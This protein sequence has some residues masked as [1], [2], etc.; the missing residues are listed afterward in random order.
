[1]ADTKISA[2][3]DGST[4]AATDRL[5]V[6]RS[7]FGSS[8]NRYVTPAYIKDYILALANT[9]ASGQIFVAPQLGTPASGTMTN[10]TGLPISTGVSGLGSNV[11]TFLAT[12]SSA[13]LASAVTDE[14]GSGALVFGTSPTITTKVT[15]TGGTVTTSTP[16]I[17]ATQTWNDS[18]VTFTGI[19]SNVTDTNSA[20]ASLLMDLQVGGSSKFAVAKSGNTTLASAATLGWSTDCLL[21]RDAADVL[22][23]RN[24]TTAQTFRIYNTYTDSSNYERGFVGWN[25]NVLEIGAAGAGTGSNSR[26]VAFIQNGGYAFTINNLVRWYQPFD[27]STDNAYD[28]GSSGANR[29]RTIYAG[30]SVVAAGVN[31]NVETLIIS[32]S[33]ETTAITTGTA[34]TTFRM[35]WGMTLTAVRASLTTA[36][37]SGTPTI[38]INDGGVSILS[39]KI[40]IDANE[41]TSTTAATPAVISDTALADDAEITIDIDVAGTNAA[42]LKVYL[43]GTRL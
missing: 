43:I 13:N 26:P 7:P 29:P 8:D 16:V 9:W 17:D 3:T 31:L 36:S 21:A 11:A 33:D 25:G 4:A 6:A 28:I 18:G 2:L 37:S 14:T 15:L 23:Q 27:F 24:S 30:T 20:A 32:V 34:K 5:P 41:K 35:P 42:G 39:T 19:K 38:D 1:M 12:P 22:A 40:T 10:C